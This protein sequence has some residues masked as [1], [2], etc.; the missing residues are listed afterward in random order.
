M[1]KTEVP[2][3]MRTKGIAGLRSFIM[4]MSGFVPYVL[5]SPWMSGLTSTVCRYCNPAA[6]S[7]RMLCRIIQGSGF[8]LF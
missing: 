5:M 3:C 6:A 7:F 1:N 8:V 2:Y 4:I